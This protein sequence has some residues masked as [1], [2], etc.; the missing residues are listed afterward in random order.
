[1]GKQRA[2]GAYLIGRARIWVLPRSQS[3][4]HSPPIRTFGRPLTFLL[5]F[6]GG[7]MECM[8]SAYAAKEKP[9]YVK[10]IATI[11]SLVA[12]DKP[13]AVPKGMEKRSVEL[14]TGFL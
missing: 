13:N 2:R 14:G 3:R 9:Y 11:K 12:R 6:G 4:Q 7:R 1:M 8:G 10:V 5:E